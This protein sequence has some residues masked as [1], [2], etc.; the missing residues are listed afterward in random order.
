MTFKI[1]VKIFYQESTFVFMA[2]F[3]FCDW[4]INTTPSYFNSY[5]LNALY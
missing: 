4:I 5:E 1:V 3:L 2:V